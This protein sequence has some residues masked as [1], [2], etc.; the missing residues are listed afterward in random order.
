MKAG[1]KRN[2]ETVVLYCDKCSI[3]V[4]H[5]VKSGK[6]VLCT[7]AYNASQYVKHRDRILFKKSSEYADDPDR[8]KST[9]LRTRSKDPVWIKERETAWKVSNYERSIYTLLKARAK[10]RGIPFNLELSDIVIPE[11]CPVLG[12]RLVRK[13][14]TSGAAYNSPSVDRIV[15]ELG[16]I[17]GNI[18]IMSNLANTMKSNA[19]ADQLRRFAAW[20]IEN[21]A[22]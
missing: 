7:V 6:C 11:F 14:G 1:R 8:F 22:A 2:A 21:I 10:K 3:E 13:T 19:N 12:M 20:V 4:E 18:Q 17:R 9:R 16:Y 5:Y 15:P